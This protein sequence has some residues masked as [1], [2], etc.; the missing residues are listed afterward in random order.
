M[1]NGM[2]DVP[3]VVGIDLG[4]TNSA[5]ACVAL[6]EELPHYGRLRMVPIP[7]LTGQGEIGRL[8]VLPSFLY[9]PGTYDLPEDLT[10]LPWE[11][12]R[13]T[14]YIVGQFARDYGARVPSRLVSSAKSWLCHG[15]VDRRAPILPWGAEG[16]RKVSPVAAT[17]A[18]LRHI[19]EAWNHRQGE[20]S[21]YHLENQLVIL[22]VP[23]SFDEVARDLTVEAAAQAGLPHVILL[24]EP[25]AAFYSWLRRHEKD[26]RQQIRPGELVLVCDVGG[27]TTDFTLITLEERG[28]GLRFERM[29]VGEHLILGG[30]NA[31]LA[32]ARVVEHGSGS[33]SGSLSSD[34]WKALCHQCRQA[35]EDI[36]AGRCR[37]KRI[38]LAGEGSRLIA[39][40][41]S[42]TLDRGTVEQVV[43]DGFFPLVDELDA[44]QDASRPAITEFGL[45]YES[46]PAVTRHLIRFMQRHHTDILHRTGRDSAAPQWL[47]FNGGSLKPR[48]I[49]ERIRLAVARWY[50]TQ[51]SE[52]PRILDNPSPEL[53]VAQGAAYY[54]LVK[55]GR[56]VRVGGGSPR[57]YYIG[58]AAPDGAVDGAAATAVC[59]TERGAQEGSRTVLE[60]HEFKVLTNQPVV[61]ELFASSYRSG[62]RAG[63]VVAVDDSMTRLSPIQT[64]VQYGKKGARARIPVTLEAAYTEIGTLALWCRSRISTHRWKLQFQLRSTAE[65]TPVAE[66]EVFA[67]EVVDSARRLLASVFDIAQPSRPPAENR[68]RLKTLVRDIGAA[69]Q[70]DR[71]RWPLGLIRTLAD[72][73]LDM[74]D[75]RRAGADFESRWL[76]LCGFLLR[77]GFGDAADAGRMAR[78]WKIYLQ[79]PLHAGQGQVRTEWWILWRR[80]AGGLKYGQQ[81]QFAQDVTPLLDPRRARRTR[82]LPA[83]ER[84]ELWMAAASMEQLPARDRVGLGE[85]LLSEIKPRKCKPQQL[86]SL[87]RIGARVPLYASVDRVVP[88]AEVRP[89]ITRMLEAN[90]RNPRPVLSALCQMARRTGDRARDLPRDFLQTVAG[91]MC[92]HG[93]DDALVEPLEKIIPVRSH[94]QDVIFG[95][96]LPAGLV[97]EKAPEK[98]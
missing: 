56:G 81:R 21:E 30:D 94:E 14:P 72:D 76:N 4:T 22:T 73:L 18:Y 59:V 83:Q 77:P 91:W 6:R 2:H 86:W 68:E 15:Q 44:A 64:V 38:T 89:W 93:A 61:F 9:L 70:R 95:E 42:A 46:D 11:R 57:S 29:A 17:A 32:L 37:E 19:R 8:E 85:R 50:G 79:G 71:E 33:G 31:D 48:V 54:G 69:L 67:S 98:G 97:L 60:A 7:Q 26:W 65:K 55:A 20:D 45:P 27:G 13:D 74:A 16:V 88:P 52:S 39:G 47:L 3:Y 5:V 75:A 78:L 87:S 80:V 62:D 23:A 10:T 40:T 41:L 28:G 1:A 58:I 12:D 34:R 92:D 82:P 53:A 66:Q 90:W 25:L 35:K 24:E 51:A 96:R 84:L 49:Q 36:L 63:D 43:V